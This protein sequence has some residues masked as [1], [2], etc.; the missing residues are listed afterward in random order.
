[1][2]FSFS[3]TTNAPLRYICVCVY[4]FIYW[5]EYFYRLI[6]KEKLGWVVSRYFKFDRC[7]EISTKLCAI[8]SPNTS[9]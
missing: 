1:M 6:H 2:D 7:C 8:G 5:G 3:V 9:V 4:I